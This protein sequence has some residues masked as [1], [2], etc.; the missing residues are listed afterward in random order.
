VTADREAE[1]GSPAAAPGDQAPPRVDEGHHTDTSGAP[2][3]GT[4]PSQAGADRSGAPQVPAGPR[5]VTSTRRRVARRP[6]GPPV[7]ATAALDRHAS[8]GADGSAPAMAGPAPDHRHAGVED[9]DDTLTD[10]FGGEASHGEQ[11][12]VPVKRRGRG[13]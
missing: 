7:S 6:A 9:A 1:T 13:H 8:A 2:V 10:A 12:H 11:A 5:L 3:D 4:G